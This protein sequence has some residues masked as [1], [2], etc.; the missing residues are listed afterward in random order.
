MKERRHSGS[1]L[2]VP[3]S[4]AW[5]PTAWTPGV[6]KD[7][8]AGPPDIPGASAPFL[9]QQ[10]AQERLGKG[11]HIEPLREAADAY[12]RAAGLSRTPSP[13]GG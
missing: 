6:G 5:A 4:A 10:I 13:P 2:P 12:A 11:L 8:G 1:L 9:A 3:A 7:A